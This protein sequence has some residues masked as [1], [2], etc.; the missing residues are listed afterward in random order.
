MTALD[1]AA[2]WILRAMM[3][4]MLGWLIWFT[5]A[6]DIETRKQRRKNYEDYKRSRE[7]HEWL[8]GKGNESSILRKDGETK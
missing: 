2:G 3:W 6:C 5:V 4:G 1:L 8:M 7:L